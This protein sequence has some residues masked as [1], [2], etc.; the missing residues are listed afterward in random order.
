[1]TTN[2]IRSAAFVLAAA[3]AGAPAI[4]QAV[5]TQPTAPV[6]HTYDTSLAPQLGLGAPW[7]GTLKLTL[8]PDGII[9]GYYYPAG[10]EVAFIPVTGGRNGDQ[11]W[12]DIGQRGRLHIEGTIRNGGTIAG[13]ALDERTNTPF[14]FTARVTG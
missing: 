12:L 7:T 14:N 2:F 5:T 13:T 3:L 4:S 1:M 10:D 11:V 8:N 6:K 9:Q